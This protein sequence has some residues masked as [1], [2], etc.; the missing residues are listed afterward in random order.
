MARSRYSRRQHHLH[1][2]A[3]AAGAFN[4]L[5]LHAGEETSGTITVTANNTE[6]GETAGVSSSSFTLTIDPVADAP[7]LSGVP[8]GT[9]HVSEGG[10]L[11]LHAIAASTDDNDPVSITISKDFGRR[12]A[13][14]QQRPAHD[15]RQQHH[16]HSGDQSRPGAQA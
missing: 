11:D 9:V 7:V 4:G 2:G 1:G 8:S 3:D 15:H 12:H 6:T 5:T 16:L 13:D 14:Q 10:T